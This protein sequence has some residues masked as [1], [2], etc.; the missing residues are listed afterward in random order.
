MLGPRATKGAC[1]SS[2][3]ASAASQAPSVC[4]EE[5][6]PSRSLPIVRARVTSVVAGALWEWPP[7]VCGY[8]RDAISLARSKV[9]CQ[10]SHADLHR[11]VATAGRP[12]SSSGPSP[13]TSSGR[14]KRISS[15]TPRWKS[16]R[17]EVG[18]FRHDPA[19]I[20]EHG[21]NP[22]LGLQDAYT[23]LAPMVDTDVYMQWLVGEVGKRAAAC[24][25]G[26]SP[27]CFAQAE[28]LA[29]QFE[30]DAI[31]NCTG[32][33]ARELARR[34]DVSASRRTGPSQERRQGDAAD[35]QAHC[36]SLD[37]SDDERGF[38]FIVPR[39]EDMLVLGGL[40][41]PRRVG[42]GDRPAQLRAGPPDVPALPGIHAGPAS[43]RDR[44]RG[45]GSRRATAGARPKRSPGSRA[46]HSNRPQL[47][48]RRLGRHILM[49]L[50]AR[51]RRPG[52]TACPCPS[53]I[54]AARSGTL[55]S[56]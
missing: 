26:R 10:A 1:S 52:R 22:G 24:S 35:H 18:G 36:I 38:I 2:A 27:G 28:S 11:S 13:T 30:V 15:I 16:S 17:T 47:R 48:P 46:R 29:R 34:A 3:P 32:L 56:M 39:G 19:L 40:A 55:N 44:R 8:H 43:R 25:S 5:A 33:G 37:D 41:E 31:V 49:G 21:V 45:A 20:A 7:A 12:A 23:H 6:L 14:S 54:D 4:A 9:W 42:P 53:P 50:R 51:S